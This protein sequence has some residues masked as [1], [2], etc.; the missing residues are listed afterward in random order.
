M[1][2]EDK[3]LIGVC[4]IST[5][6]INSYMINK[7]NKEINQYR[8]S[9]GEQSAQFENRDYKQDKKEFELN[10]RAKNLDETQSKLYKLMETINK[11][12]EALKSLKGLSVNTDIPS[13]T[14][15]YLVKVANENL[16]KPE[17]LF[18]LIERESGWNTEEVSSTNDYG[19]CQINEVNFNS[20]SERLKT[21]HPDFD[22]MDVKTNIDCMI[23]NL[24]DTRKRYAAQHKKEPSIYTLLYAYNTGQVKASMSRGGWGYSDTIVDNMKEYRRLIKY[25]SEMSTL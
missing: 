9:I 22:I 10:T 5:V 1:R 15:K 6:A 11:Q 20:Y 2:F 23:L 12:K 19:I 17:M 4:I 21:K 8:K 16:Y 14:Y 13:E 25:V 18:A 7:N 3:L 24:N